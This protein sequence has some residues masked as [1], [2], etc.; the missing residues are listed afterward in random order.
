M[1]VGYYLQISKVSADIVTL[2]EVKLY[3][4]GVTGVS[5]TI[6]DNLLQL[7]IDSAIRTAEKLMCR[8][9]LTTTYEFVF[10]WIPAVIKLKRGAFQSVESFEYLQDG[11][12]VTLATTEYTVRPSLPFGEILD[13]TCP[14]DVDDEPDNFKITFKTG[15]G[16]T[17]A[18]IPADIKNA[19]LAHIAF[20]YE[21]RG[22]CMSCGDSCMDIMV[23][24]TSKLVY[25]NNRL[26]DLD[27]GC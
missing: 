24:S 6:E 12:F 17:G 8:D 14:S 13:I 19:L 27:Y 4:K 2:D 5:T 9:L 16:D 21:N 15:Y 26:I 20:L 22:E 7:L 25:L 1:K 23:P 11:S 10:S 3:I 18:D